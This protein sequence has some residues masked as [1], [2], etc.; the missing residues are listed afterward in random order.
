MEGLRFA[1]LVLLSALLV[2]GCGQQVSLPYEK[3]AEP[4][5]PYSP[6]ASSDN[7][8]DAYARAAADVETSCAQY[9][10]RN[11]FTPAMKQKCIVLMGDALSRVQRA[12]GRKSL[13]QFRTH[14]PGQR[15]PFQKGWR[16]L[17]R[18][19]VWQIEQAA[20]DGDY[21][22]AAKRTSEAISFGFDLVGG[23]AL[24]ASLG[25]TIVDEARGAI[26]TSLA[27]MDEDALLSLKEG[28]TTALLS[29]PLLVQALENERKNM[30]AAVQF[31]QDSMREGKW[32]VI[33]R[34][35]GRDSKPA[36]DY[37]NQVRK[38]EPKR[39]AYFKAF[40]AEAK[41]EVDWLIE[42]SK[43][44]AYKRS[45]QG[46]E[47][48]AA[49]RPWRRFARHFFMTG[50][51]LL[52]QEIKTLARTRLLALHAAALYS[53]RINRSGLDGLESFPVMIRTDPYSGASFIYR[54]QGSDFRI[55]SVGTD[56]RDDGGETDESF[57]APDMLLE[58]TR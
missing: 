1:R 23:G 28:V 36:I 34:L 32:E 33:Q 27:R 22:T 16:L 35:M 11:F 58:G 40:A 15:P 13:F 42:Q 50:R 4:E 26:A 10:D 49:E 47:D 8:Y 31:V 6:A 30:R 14:K 5:P 2:A 7:A 12:A 29:R 43:L 52:S 24:D 37:L 48:G 17:G 57:A 55:Y 3:W 18:A 44:P 21:K 41:A 9:L 53:V 39:A 38:D 54:G 45:S 46:P 51:P 19:M 56:C 25:L 20:I